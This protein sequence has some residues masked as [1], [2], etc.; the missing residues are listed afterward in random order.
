MGRIGN[1]GAPSV[2]PELHQR[3]RKLFEEAIVK[4]EGQ[5]LAFLKAAC[6][7]DL[8]TYQGVVQMLESVAT[9][10]AFVGEKPRPMERI[11][12][13]VLT[14]ELGRGAMG[15]VYEAMDPLIGRSVAVKIIHL[16]LRPD[17]K[18]AEFMRDRLFREARAAGRLFHPGIVV[19]L[20]V[21]QEGDIA[22]IAMERV[23]G[24]TLER[25]LA[26]RKR[27]ELADSLDILRQTAAALDYAHQNGVVHRDIKPANIMLHKGATVK[28]ADFGI[29]K[30]MS[31]EHGT[32]TGMIMGTP[33]YMSPEQIEAQPVDGRSDQ[34]S[35]AV[36]AFEL[37]SGNRPFQGDSLATLAHMIVYG[38]RPSIRE[39]NPTLP[40]GLDE[41]LRRGLAKKPEQRYESCTQFVA[42][43]DDK[44]NSVA[45]VEDFDEFAVTQ[46]VA[47]PVAEASA[48]D[49]PQIPKKRRS[50]SL[51]Y[52]A[53]AGGA[54]VLLD[55]SLF[56]FRAATHHR[57]PVA[58][59]QPAKVATASPFA[60]KVTVPGGEPAGSVAA[61]SPAPQNP[62]PLNNVPSSQPP[63]NQA[64][65]KQ[66]P[67]NRA[68]S[69]QATSPPI[70][71][72]QS[73]APQI[74]TPQIT[75]PQSPS[76]QSPSPPSTSPPSA[77]SAAPPVIASPFARHNSAPPVAPATGASPT[78]ASR[79]ADKQA[80]GR[81]LYSEATEKLRA[82]RAKEAIDLFRQAA[83]L[84]ESHAMQDLGEIFVEGTVVAK[85]D[86]EALKWF[87][88]GADKGNTSAML[89]LGGMYELGEGVEQSDKA[90]A[91][92]FRKAVE[93]GN[94]AA[95]FN[96][97]RFYEEGTGVPRDAA[98]AKGLYQ[99]AAALGDQE[100]K[101]RLDQLR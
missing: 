86:E 89:S 12:R 37:L 98:K 27:L 59:V 46:Q 32:M 23:D 60:K 29:A 82:G 55:L 48:T 71:A 67:P 17:S 51:W 6:P 26:S 70:A 79:P 75:V 16:Q 61:P 66:V 2:S 73:V 94:P 38:D 88:R 44:L 97:G 31:T 22:F 62:A 15:V 64:P 36:V 57:I 99:Q 47:L 5:R 8:E 84:G 92:W 81:Q 54:L 90:A 34:F 30:S 52:V 3:V 9:A 42:A 19:I 68:P 4:P 100:A 53:A 78:S 72:P 41:V 83:D 35:L 96:L 24:T 39:K 11:G 21:G 91:D 101:K 87:R 25:T 43:L 85:N 1:C 50:K 74:A 80:Q 56:Y 69:K 28:V 13:Y 33:S 58:S 63:V 18:E 45:T 20:D 93:L 65:L 40:A 14:G 95:M 76:P 10:A 77:S 49:A 7:N